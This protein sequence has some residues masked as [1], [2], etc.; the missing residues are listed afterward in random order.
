MMTRPGPSDDYD[1]VYESTMM[2]TDYPY[3]QK[4]K[5][6]SIVVLPVS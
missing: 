2:G 3:I 4:M 5:T 6:N 1:L